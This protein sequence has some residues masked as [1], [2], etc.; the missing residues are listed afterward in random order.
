[1]LSGR[2]YKCDQRVGATQTVRQASARRSAGSPWSAA[3]TWLSKKV[4]LALQEE[5][6]DGTEIGGAG[7]RAASITRFMHQQLD[8]K[9]STSNNPTTDCATVNGAATIAALGQT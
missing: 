7:A 5:S 1:L 2:G 9:R 8:D 6:K 4:D 3:S